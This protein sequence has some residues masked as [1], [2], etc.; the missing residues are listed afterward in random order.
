MAPMKT[1]PLELT[2][3]EREE[4]ELRARTRKGR[5]GSARVARL[6][7]A[8]ADGLTY[9]Q[10]QE[11]LDCGPTFV[12]QWKRRFTEERLS[13]LFTRH[14]GRQ[15][16]AFLPIWASSV[17]SG[18]CADPENDTSHRCSATYSLEHLFV[19]LL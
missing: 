11:R 12:N 19:I 14:Q 10:I 16:I 1:V 13:G 6:I 18:C 5:A 2:E 7:L 4:L 9:A 3:A 8:L 15:E 17:L